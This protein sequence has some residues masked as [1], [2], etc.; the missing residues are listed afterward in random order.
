MYYIGGVEVAETLS[1]VGQLVTGVGVG[2]TQQEVRH[3]RVRAGLH[4]G[5]S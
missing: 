5:S 1:D 3:L 4:W 2:E